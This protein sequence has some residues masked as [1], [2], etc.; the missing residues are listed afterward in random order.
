MGYT[1]TFNKQPMSSGL[2]TCILDY[3]FDA[4]F[5]PCLKFLDAEAVL[6]PPVL[7]DV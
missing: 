4:N 5:E 1:F 2:T 3:L 6:S 7:N